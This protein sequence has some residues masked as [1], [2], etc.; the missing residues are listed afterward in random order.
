MPSAIELSVRFGL[1]IRKI[2]EI[3]DFLNIELSVEDFT[4]DKEFEYIARSVKKKRT[5]AYTLA[6][7]YAYASIEQRDFIFDIDA[8]FRSEYEAL[9]L[10][11]QDDEYLDNAAA[12]IMKLSTTSPDDKS[13]WSLLI[14]WIKAR[15]EAV[16]KPVGHAYLAVRLL[17][18]LDRKD[19]RDYPTVIAT[20]LNRARHRKYLDEWFSTVEKDGKNIILYHQPKGSFL[21]SEEIQTYTKK[22]GSSDP[23]KLAGFIAYSK[24]MKYEEVLLYLNQQS[25][26][27]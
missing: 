7:L 22:L 3:C 4:E 12:I 14:A 5:S 13:A 19:M 2:K 25:F 24:N 18:S 1:P 23:V 8:D 26:N 20:V 6:Y 27:L 17:L 11:I 16:R 15:L 10:P 21:S 9:K